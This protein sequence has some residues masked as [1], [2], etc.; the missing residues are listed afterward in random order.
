MLEQMTFDQ[1]RDLYKQNEE[2]KKGI[3]E[4]KNAIKEQNKVIEAVMES[5][6]N[7]KKE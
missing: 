1:L 4:Q 7:E 5:K 6:L 3:K 2:Q